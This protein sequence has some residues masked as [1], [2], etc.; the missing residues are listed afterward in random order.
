MKIKCWLDDNRKP[1]I[2][3]FWAQN[4]SEMI[5]LCKKYTFTEVS[6]DHDLTEEH[7]K[8]AFD[9]SK[10]DE[11]IYNNAK[12]TGYDFFVWMKDNNYWPEIIRIHSASNQGRKRMVDYALKHAPKT[13]GIILMPPGQKPNE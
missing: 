8:M 12:E 2:G 10:K 3:W 4:Y 5:E 6:L 9:Y 11:E 7:Y 13:S 1:P